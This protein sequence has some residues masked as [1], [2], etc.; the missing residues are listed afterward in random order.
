MGYEI[1]VFVGYGE[2]VGAYRVIVAAVTE[3]F[4]FGVIVLKIFKGDFPV[5]SNCL[6][7]C[8]NTAVNVLVVCLYPVGNV[9][10]PLQFNSFVL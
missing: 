3:L 6:G 8:V 4:L 9:D 5:C 2:A 7:K 1:V 10:L